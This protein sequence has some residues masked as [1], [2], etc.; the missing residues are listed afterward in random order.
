MEI[1]QSRFCFC[2]M[3]AYDF[4]YDPY[5]FS[6][7]T[8]TNHVTRSVSSWF[9]WISIVH[10]KG[11]RFFCLLSWSSFFVFLNK[12]SFQV[13]P[14]YL[15]S[16][17]VC[18][19]ASV[20][21]L[22]W[23]LGWYVS[24]CLRR[25]GHICRWGCLLVGEMCCSLQKGLQGKITWNWAFAWAKPGFLEHELLLRG[26]GGCYWSAALVWMEKLAL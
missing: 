2:H 24:T 8:T 12:V 15:N 11:G 20:E 3:L 7:I 14:V 19:R 21:E 9:L 5:I 13:T 6:H 16:P 10:F 23:S 4:R 17:Q 18:G 25:G 1:H 26:W 22:D